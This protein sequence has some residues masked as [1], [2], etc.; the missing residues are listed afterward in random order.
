MPQFQPA[1]ESRVPGA[2]GAAGLMI[3]LRE[4]SI[5]SLERRIR[6]FST[7]GENHMRIQ[8]RATIFCA[9]LMAVAAFPGT[10]SAQG[11][12]SAEA[13][14]HAKELLLL[15]DQD[16]NGKVSKAEFMTFMEAEFARLDVNHDGELDVAELTKLHY[17][18]ETHPSR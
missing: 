6:M 4:S 9:A 14:A 3:R 5:V 11:D 17:R 12:K 13:D 8:A 10:A 18:T 1:W 15:M 16:K 2:A 7:P